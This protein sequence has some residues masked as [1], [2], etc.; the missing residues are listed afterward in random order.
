MPVG[1]ARAQRRSQSRLCFALLAVIAFVS[2]NV[3]AV[4]RELARAA[5]VMPASSLSADMVHS[6]PPV[7]SIAGSSYS[8]E[9]VRNIRSHLVGWYDANRRM[10]PWRGDDLVT[11]AK[12][13][14]RSAYGPK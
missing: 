8:D 2:V 13:P 10:L 5:K 9:D 3:R 14:E 12:T 6:V 4:G 7:T 1:G 11:Y